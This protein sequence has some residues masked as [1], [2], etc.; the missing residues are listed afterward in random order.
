MGYFMNQCVSAADFDGDGRSDLVLGAGQ[1]VQL[2]RNL[3]ARDC[4]VNGVAD[5]CDIAALVSMDENENGIPDECE[6][7]DGD[8]TGDGMVNVNDLLVVIGTWGSCGVGSR[9][10][11]GRGGSSGG[12]F[13]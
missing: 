8:I 2:L 13:E 12:R 4:N 3:P 11:R 7:P 10:S 6:T 5:E 1:S 9:R